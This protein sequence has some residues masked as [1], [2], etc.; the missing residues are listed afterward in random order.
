M[1]GTLV[2]VESPSKAKTIEKYL[3][4]DYTVR[5]SYGHIRDLPKSELGVDV[6]HGFGVTYVV[7]EDSKKHVQELKRALKNADD[8]ILATDYDREGEAIAFHV[9]TLLGQDP[10][11]AKRVTFTEITKDV[12]LESFLHPR[13]IDLRLFDA[14]EARRVLDRLVGYQISPI[15]W[16]R[17]RPGLSAGRVQSVAVRL[18]V[19]REREIQAFVPIEYWSV[20]VRLTPTDPEQPFTARLTEI[21]EGKLASAP[22]KK[23]VHLA[24]EADAAGHVERLRDARYRVA[25]VEQKERKRSPS[26]P[27]TTSTL[28]QE[29]ARKLGYGARRTMSIAQR[30]Y[31]GVDVPGEGSVGLITYMRTDSVNIADTAL[32]EIAEL[33]K[34]E[35]GEAYTIAEPR[36]FKTRSRNAQEAHEAI[37][38]TSV[39]RSPAR[40][41]ASL[42]R[43][44]LRLYTMIWQRTMASQ[45]AEARFNQVGV[46]I[47]AAAVDGSTY[48]L[49]ATGQTM[50]FDGF[51]RVY[52]E[53]RDD[54]PDEDA[55]SMLPTL[56]A[57]QALRMLEVLPEQ[58][59]TQPPPRF[60]EA[61]LVKTME[62]L[63]IGRPSTYASTI[64][65]IQ[66][67]KY[68]RLEDKRFYPEDVGMVV[69]DKL[70][71]HFPDI[72]DVNFTAYMEKELDDIAEGD[73][74]KLQMLEEFN[75]PFTR[76]LEKAE[77]SFERYK[78]ELNELCPLCP[79]EGRE[80]GQLEVKLGRF[81]KFIGC[82]NY[83]ECRY[84]RNMDGS[85]R[86]EPEM[87]DEV[88]PQCGTHKLQK[89]VGRFGPFVGCSGYPDCTYIK[90]D[91]PK[92]IGVTCPQCKQGELIEKRSR[93]GTTFFSCERYPECDFAA[94]NPPDADHP[95]PECGSLLLRRPKSLRCWNCGAELDLEYNVT[96]SG[97]VEEEAAA[98]A[99]KATAKAARAAAKA[100][101]AKK[102][103]KKKTAA[104][105]KTTKKTAAK[106]KPAPA[107]EP[108]VEG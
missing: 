69:T 67:R 89:R 87:L 1:P 45:M 12:I 108:A 16:R 98:R 62:E 44:Q 21:P 82:T 35:Y 55:E 105:K 99:A 33:V 8:V 93:F 78:E 39:L 42:D 51:R 25:K 3:G 30:L 4:G 61:S 27:F 86:P 46:D 103:T 63:G 43:D 28:Q 83:P 75:G 58:H 104:K 54:A 15:L 90:K 5:A 37:R 24:A 66:E 32:R 57:E 38:P 40:V 22:D 95:C 72:V 94:G 48:G 11:S 20:D 64:G 91:P 36:R 107:P 74:A 79:T 60:S 9:A 13:A 96:K 23:G 17:V 50:I 53:G 76:A 14:Q 81:G 34:N 92:T 65:T 47:E 7:P 71:E 18:I 88:C 77:H 80:P 52:F 84:I 56:T 106:K 68:V 41:A 59:F 2:V 26:P 73:L 19:E 29:A 6:D 49:R 70:V 10:A 101:T 97:D 100:Q 102:T 31:E 85:E